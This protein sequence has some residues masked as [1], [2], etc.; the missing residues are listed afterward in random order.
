MNDRRK[1]NNVVEELA[2]LTD[3]LLRGE[4]S[5]DQSMPDPDGEE[6]QLKEMVRSVVRLAPAQDVDQSMKNRIRANLAAKWQKDG[7]AVRDARKEWKLSQQKTQTLILRYAIILV[8]LIMASVLIA[9]E[10]Q[11]I[12]PGAAQSQGTA[13]VIAIV[14]MVILGAIIFFWSRHKS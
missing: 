3:N 14:L 8:V 6:A 10:F 13:N 9:N 1:Q 7:P 2:D 11:A 5:V 4:K 12:L